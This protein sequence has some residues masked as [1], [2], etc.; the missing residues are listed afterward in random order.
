MPKAYVGIDVKIQEGSRL[1][2]TICTWKGKILAP[3]PLKARRDFL[4]PQ[5]MGNSHVLKDPVT[6]NF[7]E[8]ALEY[9]ESITRSEGLEVACIA[10]DAPSD[11]RQPD[12]PL[13]E[14][15]AA[16]DRDNIQ[17]FKTPSLDDFMHIRKKVQDHFKAGGQKSRVP[18]A[19]QLWMLA[20]FALFR[21]FEKLAECREIYPQATM[22]ILRA[23]NMHKSTSIGLNTQIE[24]ISRHTGWPTGDPDEPSLDDI[25]FGSRHDKLDA[26]SAAWI[27][28]LDVDQLKAFGKSPDDVIWVPDPDLLPKKTTVSL[29]APPRKK[30][31]PPASNQTNNSSRSRIC[32]ACGIKEFSR[33]PLGWDAHAAHKCVGLEGKTAKERKLEFKTRFQ[34]LF[35]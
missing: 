35:K 25:C 15:E 16:L 30:P 4:P 12:L 29:K 28:A 11:Y 7:A 3:L 13:R 20:G 26:Y 18:H 31:T 8:C 27:A 24:A 6:R 23:A 33:W 1:P 21:S 19:N 34:H 17:F 32:P 5:G 2:V 14:A 22:Q 9:V 10:I